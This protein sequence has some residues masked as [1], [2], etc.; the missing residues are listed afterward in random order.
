[1][2]PR[3]QP[4]ATYWPA[5]EGVGLATGIVIGAL[6]HGML[7]SVLRRFGI[8]KEHFLL[9]DSDEDE[10]EDD[11]PVGDEHKL[12][13]CV[14]TDLKMQ[15]GKIAA[16]VGHATLGAYKAAARAHPNAVRVWERHAQPKIAVQIR[17]HAEARELD[18][19]ARRKGLVT[20]M[21]HDAGRTQI[22]AGSMT[23]IAIGPGPASVVNSV[24]GHLKLL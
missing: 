17:S 19:A 6:C 1:M 12:V 10:G 23:V 8:L 3:I 22:A 13:L 14:R 2:S 7:K 18:A 24:T 20:Y 4:F 11:A 5:R 16:Q 21:V 9:H 15:K